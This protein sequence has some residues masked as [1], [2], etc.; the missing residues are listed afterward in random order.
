MLKKPLPVGALYSR[1]RDLLD[2][3]QGAGISNDGIV[4]CCRLLLRYRGNSDGGSLC[5]LALATLERWGLDQADAFRC[6]RM[7]WANGYKPVLSEP[8]PLVGSGSDA[9]A[10]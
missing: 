1:D 6:S 5:H 7:L 4:E 3:L 8:V 9:T 10:T 2:R